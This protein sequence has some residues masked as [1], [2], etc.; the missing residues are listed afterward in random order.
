MINFDIGTF[1]QSLIILF[2]TVPSNLNLHVFF[3]SRANARLPLLFI[4]VWI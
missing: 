1:N 3:S 4:L 2:A